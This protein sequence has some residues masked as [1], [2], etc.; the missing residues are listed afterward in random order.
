MRRADGS[1]RLPAPWLPDRWTSSGRH[2]CPTAAGGRSYR[3]CP[4]CRSKSCRRPEPG[5]AAPA[6]A[7]LG[8]VELAGRFRARRSAHGLPVPGWQRWLHRGMGG[9]AVGWTGPTHS[10]RAAAAQR[11]TRALHARVMLYP[12]VTPGWQRG[13][14]R[15]ASLGRGSTYVPVQRVARGPDCLAPA[16]QFEGQE[17]AENQPGRDY[18]KLRRYSLPTSTTKDGG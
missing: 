1:G 9:N 8:E 12:W 2:L 17:E 18:S 11:S 3:R 6:A 14:D 16:K 15:S 13:K 7:A 4:C 5:P 10:R